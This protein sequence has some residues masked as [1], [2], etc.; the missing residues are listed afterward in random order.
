M[1]HV[2]DT[3]IEDD[4][5][6]DLERLAGIAVPAALEGLSGCEVV[7]LGCDDARIAEL[8]ADFRGKARPTNVLSWPSAER[9]PGGRPDGEELG[10]IAIAYETCAREAAEQGKTFEAHVI[11][12]LIHATLH[13]LGHDHEEPEEAERMEATEVE[14]VKALGFPDPYASDNV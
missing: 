10:D 3:V 5:W 9:E 14:L 4:R 8:N 13:L 11:H 2:I 6:S 12:L 1:T 7:V